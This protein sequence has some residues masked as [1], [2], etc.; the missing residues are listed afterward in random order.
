MAKQPDYEAAKAFALDTLARDLSPTLVY[1]SLAHTRDE[2]LPAVTRFAEDE[3]VTGEALLLL[4]TAA[5]F[6]DIGFVE[7]MRDHEQ[8]GG[9]LAARVLPDL[10]YSDAQIETIR[11]TIMVTKL[12]QSPTTLL[13][14]ILADADLDVLGQPNF[15]ERNRAL[16]AELA[17]YGHDYDDRTWFMQQHSFVSNHRYFTEAAR[18]H[19][20][21]QKIRN[22][23]VLAAKLASLSP[24]PL[25]P[26][27]LSP[28]SLSPEQE[29][30][31]MSTPTDIEHRAAILRA[32]DIFSRTPDTVLAEVVK[33]LEPQHFSTGEPIF[34]KGD[35]GDCMYIIVSGRV[36]V[37]DGEMV[38]NEL[39]S[40]DFFGE[41]ALID[42]ERRSASVTTVDD[43][44]LL[45]LDQEPFYR[46]METQ[47]DVSKAIIKVLSQRVR[48]RVSDMAEDFEYIQQ[49]QQLTA[50]AAALEAGS[51]DP[52]SVRKV[53]ERDDPLGQLA[54]VFGRMALE[55]IQ[56]EEALKQQVQ[57]LRIEIDNAKKAKQVAA[58]TETD[59]FKLLQQ[60]ARELQR[61][62]R[63][64]GGE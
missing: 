53:A 11:A 63:N 8:A 47:P 50:A 3:G 20:G 17:A 52:D 55:V 6:H 18:R 38:L 43:T 34:Y 31:P 35:P 10:D 49:M 58:I 61:R 23:A 27:P 36:R 28:A 62:R 21:G 40:R 7:Q 29:N 37:H 33:L 56:R 25:S 44:E 54:R 30:T 39:H 46:L 19:C 51:Y 16:R 9:A 4:K 15:L 14:A 41:M 60:K 57:E 42:S 5:L 2:V 64:R 45:R 22:L 26:A 59:D 24:A 32:V 13:E 48:A 12:P 1:H